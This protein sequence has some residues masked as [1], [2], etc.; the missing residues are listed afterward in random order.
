MLHYALGEAFHGRK[1]YDQAFI[2]FEAGNSLRRK[3]SAYDPK[4]TSAKIDSLITFFDQERFSAM[5]SRSAVASDRPIFIVG[6]PR[7]GTTLVEQILSAHPQVFAAGELD[8]LKQLTQRMTLIAQPST[9]FPGCLEG[10]PDGTLQKLAEDYINKLSRLAP[11]ALRVTDKMPWNIHALGLIAL[12]WPNAKIVHCVRGPM[13]TCFSCYRTYFAE[14]A[15]AYT[16]DLAELGH[17]FAQYRRLAEHWRSVL[18][19]EMWE[20]HYE[21]LVEE[22]DI[23]IRS[24][25]EFCGLPWDEGCLEFHTSGRPSKTNPLEVRRP[26]NAG[27]IGSWKKYESHLQPLQEALRAETR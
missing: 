2:H 26:I 7:S 23:G 16:C 14:N 22:P 15:H 21:T 5:G 4:D 10:I 20:V 6:M 3:Q 27:S 11:N 24:L 1:D 19:V 25:V 18:P 9:D 13:D 8:F 17:Y 12:M